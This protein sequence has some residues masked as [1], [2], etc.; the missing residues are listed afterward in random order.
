MKYKL[1]DIAE[2]AK[3]SVST[4]CRVIN[5]KDIVKP[6]TRE[7]VLDAIEAL[8]YKM[9]NIFTS[10]KAMA[11]YTIGI[12]LR[13]NDYKKTFEIKYGIEKV[14]ETIAFKKQVESS[15]GRTK[16]FEMDDLKPVNLPETLK[17]EKINGIIIFGAGDNDKDILLKLK[18][19]GMPFI[20][21][22]GIS[23]FIKDNRMSFVEYD[24]FTGISNILKY[25]KENGRTNL[26]MINGPDQMWVC[27]ERRDAFYHFI[28]EYKISET[29]LFY[30]TGE[31]DFKTG[32]DGV[33]GLKSRGLLEN[34]NGIICGSDIIAIGAIREL[35]RL[36]IDIPGK[37]SVFGYDDTPICEYFNPPISSIKRD[38]KNYST[39]IVERLYDLIRTKNKLNIQIYIKTYPVFRKST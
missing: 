11:N 39:Y 24:D 33:L 8:D 21:T 19:I 32:Q 18:D 37:V 14:T 9:D 31:F 16:F 1:K 12:F 20:V 25:F 36:G 34:V 29:P 38:L 27:Q 4:V 3:V 7:R 22:N 2:Y 17:N 10:S 13:E 28:K 30:Y 6:E 23:D 26:A 35:I 5:N 15:G